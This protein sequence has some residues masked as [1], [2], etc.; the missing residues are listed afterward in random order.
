MTDDGRV[1]AVVELM[2]HRVRPGAI[3]DAQLGGATLLRIEHPSARDNLD[4]PLVEYYAPSALFSIRPCTRDEA[5]RLAEYRWPTE[6]D[7]TLRALASVNDSRAYIDDDS[8]F[9]S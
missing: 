7:R 4:E 6:A 3:S 5:V 1:Y 8:E 2:G 9:V